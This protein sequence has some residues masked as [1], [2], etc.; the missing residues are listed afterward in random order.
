MDKLTERQVT[1]E[2][3]NG[4]GSHV[5]DLFAGKFQEERLE[6]MRQMQALYADDVQA[7][8]AEPGLSFKAEA[9]Y[10]PQI[11]IEQDGDALYAD[12]LDLDKMQHNKLADVVPPDRKPLDLELVRRVTSDLEAGRPESLKLAL[13]GKFIEERARFLQ[14]VEDLNGND[15]AA[16]K[17]GVRLSMDLSGPKWSGNTMSVYRYAPGGITTSNFWNNPRAPYAE[18]LDMD[19]G[20]RSFRQ[21]PD[22][23]Q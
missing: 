9:Y 16:Q 3:E 13:D 18:T 20:A 11:R 4:D 5:P 2:L 12:T 19:T 21:A 15:V 6:S 1:T 17:T 10:N 14:S 23:R 7:G 22:D 8:R